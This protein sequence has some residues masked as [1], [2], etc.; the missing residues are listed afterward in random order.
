[1]PERKPTVTW[2]KKTIDGGGLALQLLSPKGDYF[3]STGMGDDMGP[4]RRF[5]TASVTKTFT[6]AA[7]H[8]MWPL[9]R[10]TSGDLK[11]PHSNS[12]RI[13]AI[14]IFPVLTQ[15]G[16]AHLLRHPRRGSGIYCSMP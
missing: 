11:T 7:V 16:M 9:T 3:L 6:A 8:F 10:V 14:T 12:C 4:G 13:K 5:R 1:V 2:L 15:L